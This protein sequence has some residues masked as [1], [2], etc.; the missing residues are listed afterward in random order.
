MKQNQ[1][2]AKKAN[3]VCVRTRVCVCVC[4]TL[5]PPA[6][7]RVFRLQYPPLQVGGGIGQG[8]GGAVMELQLVPVRLIVQQ[9]RVQFH[10]N[11]QTHRN[12]QECAPSS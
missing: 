12:K 7:Q 2:N 1:Q 5:Q 8:Q 3:N 11:L 4:L 6:T 9:S 10:Q